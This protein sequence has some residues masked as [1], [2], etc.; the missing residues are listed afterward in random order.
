MVNG[1]TERKKNCTGPAF[2]TLNWC[3]QNKC[4]I[5][6]DVMAFETA[7][8]VWYSSN[9]SGMLRGL[10]LSRLLIMV[11]N[12]LRWGSAITKHIRIFTKVQWKRRDG[13]QA[14]LLLKWKWGRLVSLKLKVVLIW[15]Y[16]SHLGQMVLCFFFFNGMSKPLRSSV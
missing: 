16:R 4:G 9:E 12:Q 5:P 13:H 2:Y 14:H 11:R 3:Q 8:A 7:S 10:I 1:N 6:W 15:F